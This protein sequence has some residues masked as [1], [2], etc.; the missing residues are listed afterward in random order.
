[1]EAITSATE[2]IAELK[3]TISK[4]RGDLVNVQSDM[5]DDEAYLK[6]LTSQCEAK[7]TD[8][9]QRASMRGDE[10]KAL[11]QALKVIG[12]KVNPADKASSK[13][14]LVQKKRLATVKAAKHISLLQAV[15]VRPVTSFLAR[16][17]ELSA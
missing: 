16:Q 3:K 2:K 6:D 1:M 13:L 11:A 4:S 5:K 17:E 12:D 7:A 14:N 15:P 10:V 9:D 8:F